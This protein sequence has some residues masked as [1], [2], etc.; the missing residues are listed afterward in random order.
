VR[1]VGTKDGESALQTRTKHLRNGDERQ[2]HPLVAAGDVSLPPREEVSG[3]SPTSAATFRV[4]S[5]DL[6]R[7]FAERILEQNAAPSPGNS[8]RS[9]VGIDWSAVEAAVAD[10]RTLEQAIGR[11]V[12]IADQ[13]SRGLSDDCQLRVLP[14]WPGVE[15]PF[16]AFSMDDVVPDFGDGSR[17]RSKVRKRVAKIFGNRRAEVTLSVAEPGSA[18]PPPSIVGEDHRSSLTG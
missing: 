3:A 4:G 11:A 10:A 8:E 14:T 1:F 17:Y 6:V 2:Q 13:M 12:V 9:V 15:D 5:F 7:R 18:P 16:F